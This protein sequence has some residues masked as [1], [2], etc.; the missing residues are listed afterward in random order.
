MP[1]PVRKI[2]LEAQFKDQMSKGVKTASTSVKKSFA[3]MAVAVAAPIAG[4][5]TLRSL[6]RTGLELA[7]LAAEAE[8]VSRSFDRLALLSGR[9]A[10]VFINELRAAARGTISD[11]ELM[12]KANESALLAGEDIIRRLPELI[13]IA[14]ASA[15]ATGQS[16]EFLFQSI[17]L[18]IG[19]Q[20]KLILDNL[21]IIVQVDKANAAYAITLG[22]QSAAL[23]EA[24]KK[25]AFLNA[26]V[27]SGQKII[28]AT[29]DAYELATDRAAKLRA[30][31]QNLLLQI[32]QELIPIVNK[33][34]DVLLLELKA[35]RDILVGTNELSRALARQDQLIQDQARLRE[36]L[37][38]EQE[39][40]GDPELQAELVDILTESLRNNSE[41]LRRNV[42]LVREL[43]GERDE[44]A[45]AA[46]EEQAPPE[47][48][49]QVLLQKQITELL[50]TEEQRRA[51]LLA[52]I[53]TSEGEQRLARIT[54]LAKLEVSII[55][56]KN[57]RI[58]D[59]TVSQSQLLEQIGFAAGSGQEAIG[60]KLAVGQ[61]KL[62]QETAAEALKIQ[63]IQAVGEA[64]KSA[65]FPANLIPAALVAGKF[66]LLSAALGVA[67]G[68]AIAAISSGGGG[69]EQVQPT[70]IAPIAAGFDERRVPG[71]AAPEAGTNVQ[72]LN[73][74]VQTLDPASVDWDKVFQDNIKPAIESGLAREVIV[75]I[76]A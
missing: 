52:A 24:E 69:I 55:Q 67:G 22:K 26:V 5:L 63:Q 38:R 27:K 44:Q 60:R 23:T 37:R 2:S 31:Q 20:S 62:L 76:P 54:E 34:R 9:T 32:G 16:V 40:G 39:R 59:F 50:L 65:P 8:E 46:V 10:D 72:Q 71:A 4:F 58:I 68:A 75:N 29:G 33:F 64:L 7:D 14:R 13:E 6:A 74:T 66:A 36:R 47:E 19:R 35:I 70:P 48:D 61:I 53:Q 30:E 17:V 51:F 18:G 43:R 3:S 73:L 11:L 25:Q 28:E 21:G 41:E 57:Q 56:R 42:E 12:K 15:A 49:F 1:T 45:D